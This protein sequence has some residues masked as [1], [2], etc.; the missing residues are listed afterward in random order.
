MYPKEEMTEFEKALYSIQVVQKGLAKMNL[1]VVIASGLMWIVTLGASIMDALKH[2]IKWDV[3]QIINGVE[4][5]TTRNSILNIGMSMV[6][7]FMFLTAVMSYSVFVV[8]GG[9]TDERG[10][11]L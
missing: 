2:G 7:L 9:A 3:V 11:N 6:F 5:V 10:L 8:L 1:A 4:T